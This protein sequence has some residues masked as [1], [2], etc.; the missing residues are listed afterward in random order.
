MF[1]AVCKVLPRLLITDVGFVAELCRLSFWKMGLS[2]IQDVYNIV[3][4]SHTRIYK[5]IL[6]AY[7]QFLSDKVHSSVSLFTAVDLLHNRLPLQKCAYR[8]AQLSYSP[9]EQYWSSTYMCVSLF[10]DSKKTWLILSTVEVSLS[11]STA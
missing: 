2:I 3:S 7:C 1:V 6:K 5:H 10:P 8:A 9:K 4:L 11:I